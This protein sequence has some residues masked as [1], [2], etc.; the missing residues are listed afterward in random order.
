MSAPTDKVANGPDDKKA[1]KKQEKS[2]FATAVE[3]INPWNSSRSSTPTPKEK[4]KQKD[5]PPPPKPATSSKKAEDHASSTI[6]G[7]SIRRYPADCP[8]LNVKWFHAVDVPK[9]KPQYLKG[10]KEKEDAKPPS[11][12][13]K[14]NPF[15]AN[16]SRAIE[17]AYQKLLEEWEDSR[18]RGAGIRRMPS[19]SIRKPTESNKEQPNTS[20]DSDTHTPGQG[21]RV[22]VNEDFLFDVDIEQRELAPVYWLGPIYDVQRG[23]WFYQEGSTLRP[24]EENL[25][26]QLE[27]GYLKIKPVGHDLPNSSVAMFLMGSV[28]AQYTDL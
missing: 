17:N 16:D 22:P 6:Y 4:D 24:C 26:A 12:P 10:K 7:Q 19:S 15:S 11:P 14:F 18:G 9:R 20:I 13:K 21:V 5:M 2:Y 1:E 3:S 28:P 23:S 8:P 27:E 25:A